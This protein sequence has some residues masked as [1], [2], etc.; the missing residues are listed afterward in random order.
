MVAR[1]PG[2]GRCGTE[3]PRIRRV[4]LSARVAAA[5]PPDPATTL[6]SQPSPHPNCCQSPSTISPSSSRSLAGQPIAPAGP[7]WSTFGPH[8]TGAERFLTV[9]SGTPF[10]QVAEAIQGKQARVQNPEG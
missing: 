9:S 4:K 5:S 7:A 6:L 1:R 10:A 8:A 3:G 2:C